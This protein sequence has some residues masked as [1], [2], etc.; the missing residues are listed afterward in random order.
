MLI[1][2]K[3][4]FY[5][6]AVI[7]VFAAFFIWQNFIFAAVTPPSVI[8]SGDDILQDGG[9]NDSYDALLV[10]DATTGQANPT[11]WELEYSNDAGQ[12]WNA[13][14]AN[15]TII[16][17][18]HRIYYWST[19]KIYAPTLLIRVRMQEGGVWSDYWQGSTG[20]S[21]RVTNHGAHYFVE[22]FNDATFQ[23]ATTRIN[24]D[25]AEALVEL[26]PNPPNYHPNGTVQSTNLLNRVG[27]GNVLSVAFQPVQWP[28]GKTLEY[29]ISNNGNDW[30]GDTSGTPK[31]N[32]W[33]SFPLQI[34]PDAITV[35]FN[36]PAGTG[37]YFKVHMQTNQT[38]VTPQLFQLRFTWQENSA[39]QACFIVSPTQSLNP[40]QVYSYN[41]NCS[42]D[43]E[44]S[45]ANLDFRWDWENDGVFDTVWETGFAGY[46]KT[47]IF[48]STSTFVTLLEVRDTNNAVSSFTNSINELGVDGAVSGWLWSSNYGWT[49]L[50][51]DNS[52]YGDPINYCPPNY[53]WQMNPDYTM[54]GWAWDSNLGWVCLGATCQP[55]GLTPDGSIA[56]A[57]YSRASGQV[58]GWG[59]YLTYN[60]SGWLQLRGNWC[61]AGLPDTPDSC[62]HVNLSQRS[63]K[64]YGWAGGVEN[65]VLIGPGWAQFEGSLNVP[66]LETKYGSI[67]SQSHVGTSNTSAAP[68]GRFNSSYCILAGGNIVNLNSE[69]PSCL[70]SAYRNLGFPNISNKYKTVGGIIDFGRIL[71][72]GQ[73]SYQSQD[74]DV[75]LPR[76][77]AGQVYYFGGAGLNSFTIDNPMTFFNARNL[78]SSGAGTVVI[79]GDLYINSNLYYESSAVSGQIEN[80][81]ALA[82][83]VKGDVIVAPNVIN[84]VGNFIVL[85]KNGIACPNVSCGNFKTGNDSANHAQLVVNGMA[86]AKQFVFERFFKGGGEPAEKII[87]D[88]RILV[89]TPPG[90]KDLSKGLPLWREAYSTLQIE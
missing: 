31:P 61:N 48:N 9:T 23:G 16:A 24:W 84:L 47:H 58:T 19:S 65:G 2:K 41:A 10:L 51:C 76:N 53:G 29:Q 60:Q 21:H 36:G 40:A 90:L 13:I 83:I 14:T 81:A 30:Y 25:I 72:G 18:N 85:G 82:W 73:T 77:L 87:Y 88:G 49:S 62:V 57:V 34:L 37:L 78:N 39:P 70:L 28:F 46:I 71:N 56:Q 42:S 11:A 52:Y 45:L 38:S 59:K 79:D 35:P 32:T 22:S 8:L 68:A 75:N 63:L 6:I 44:D 54:S 4:N 12:S 3:L 33:F 20:L 69:N 1:L 55:Y 80:L 7:L 64:G 17:N 26:G 74:V 66:W 86:M 50:N 5:L 15:Y 27:N 67:Y 89:N 43:Y